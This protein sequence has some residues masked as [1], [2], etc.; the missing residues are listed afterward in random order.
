MML[1]FMAF[2]CASA[3]VNPPAPRANTGYVDFYSTTDAEVCWEVRD[4]GDS[5]NDFRTVFSDVKPVQGDVLR[6]PF[7]PGHHRLRIT[8]LN[9]AILKPAQADVF[10]E[11]EKITPLRVILTEGG[12]TTVL[13]KQTTMGGT[14]SGRGGRRVKINS[15]ESAL[16]TISA[17]AD[18]A[19]PYQPKEQMPYTN[20]SK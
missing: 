15:E 12:A 1:L 17:V 4:G 11:N 13:S 9:R 14:P 8:F 6:L 2:G 5:G 3:N 20:Q 10:V 18:A 7:K 19:V 16:F